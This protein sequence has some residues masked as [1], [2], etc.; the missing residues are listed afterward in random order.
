MDRRVPPLRPSNHG[1]NPSSVAA[2]FFIF[3]FF[4]GSCVI[5]FLKSPLSEIREIK[6]EGNRLVSDRDVLKSIHLMKGDSYFRWDAQQAEKSLQS[7]PEI[8]SAFV[9]KMFPGKVSIRVKEVKWVGYWS[10]GDQIYP[11]LSDG[12]VLKQHPWEKEV[13]RPLVRGF[14]QDRKRALVAKGLSQLPSEVLSEISEVQPGDDTTY[15][16]LVKIYTRQNHLIRVRARDIG[17]KVK[18]YARFKDRPPGTLNL[19]K[20]HWFVPEVQAGEHKKRQE[21]KK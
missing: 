2:I 1:R 18:H 9:N 17:K 11:L 21:L 6:I 19:L 5:L 14:D 8:R 16:N 3:L 13:D 7:L 10:H 15:A 4:V 12:S 20:S